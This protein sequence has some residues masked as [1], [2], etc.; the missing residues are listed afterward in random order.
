MVN[1]ISRP[2]R[3]LLR[4][5]WVDE[6]RDRAMAER[7]CDAAGRS[8]AAIS[9]CAHRYG[10]DEAIRLHLPLTSTRVSY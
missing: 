1:Q 3:P 8:P 4:A 5:G 7:A 9:K 6:T 10:S 2:G